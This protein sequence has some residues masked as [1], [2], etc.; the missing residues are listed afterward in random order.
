MR[1]LSQRQRRILD[2][3][4]RFSQR[5]GYPPSIREIGQ[6]VGISS[7]SVVDY[8]LKVLER[9]GYIRRDREVS[10]GLELTDVSSARRPDGAVRV[11]IVGRI[12]AGEPIEAV[13]GHQ[14]EVE[15]SEKLCA[16]GCF[17][18]QVKGKS[19]I[20]DLIDDGDLVVIRPQESADDG[21]I[22]VALLT[23]G[24]TLEGRATLKRLYREKDRIRLQPANSSMEPIYVSG[25]ELRVQGK[26]VA[27]I[28]QL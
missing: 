22:V 28:R 14:D 24:P 15:I 12:A 20:E 7:T 21:D 27:V 1:Q 25:E 5:H 6:E 10:R 13:Q 3:I 17:A 16:E 4:A 26:V 9:Q 23:E 11:P 18:L 19:M 2:F 8:N